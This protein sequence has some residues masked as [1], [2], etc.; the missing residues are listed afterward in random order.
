MGVYSPRVGKLLRLGYVLVVAVNAVLVSAV[1]R[2]NALEVVIPFL[3]GIVYVELL[4]TGKGCPISF[5]GV[6]GVGLNP[7]SVGRLRVFA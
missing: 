4:V 2:R 7:Q 6:N 3:L 1:L 5:R